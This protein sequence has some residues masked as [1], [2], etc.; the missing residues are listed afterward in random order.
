M[1]RE[2]LE[3]DVFLAVEYFA[4]YSPSNLSISVSRLEKTC[5]SLQNE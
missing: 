2:A 5:L 1:R 4:K 3:F